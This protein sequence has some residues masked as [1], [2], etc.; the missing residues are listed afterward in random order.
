MV[1]KPSEIAPV[2]GVLFA[3]AVHSIGLPK[4][5]F[6]LLNGDGPSVGQ[7]MAGHPDVDVVSSTGSTRAGIMVAKTAAD[8][9]KR[10][11]Q[12]LGGKSANII[13]PDADFSHA[14]SQG[15]H[16]VMRNSGQ[17]CDAPTRML[18]PQHRL[19]EVLE[20]AKGEAEKYIVGNLWNNV[21]M[22]G[23][24]VSQVQFNKIQALVQK[25]IDAGAALITGG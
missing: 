19:D 20:K 21:T 8:T 1:L 4:G 22:I 25:G 3:E 5:V 10:V 6:N 9:V 14:V 2:S 15:V 7:V 17:S 16:A 24:V 18:L 12:E 11:S 23:P 13:L